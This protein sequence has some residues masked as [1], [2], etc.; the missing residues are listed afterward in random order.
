MRDL[1]VMPNGVLVVVVQAVLALSESGDAAAVDEL[2]KAGAPSNMQVR[3]TGNTA[4]HL[5]ALANNK[6]MI[7]TL[8]KS[9]NAL[10]SSS[11]CI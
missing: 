11:C 9:G 7:N 1:R 10:D 3:S 4:L 2:V 6:E 5:A 8:I